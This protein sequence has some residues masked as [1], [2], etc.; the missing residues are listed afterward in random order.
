VWYTVAI[1]VANDFPA[2]SV[3]GV[4]VQAGNSETAIEA[5]I[6]FATE[7]GYLLDSER[8]TSLETELVPAGTE[9]QNE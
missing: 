6:A 4:R 8:A 2:L 9:A 1:P 5:A 7:R 3:V